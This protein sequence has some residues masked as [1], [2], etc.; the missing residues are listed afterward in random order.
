MVTFTFNEC[1]APVLRAGLA[2]LYPAVAGSIIA[3]TAYVWLLSRMRA[4]AVTSYA[5]VNP[6][7]ALLIG[8]WFGNET[9]GVRTVAGAALVLLS[10]VVV[11]RDQRA[12]RAL[13]Y[14]A[15]RNVRLMRQ[16]P[17]R[18]LM[19]SF[20]GATPWKAS[21]AGPPQTTTSPLSKR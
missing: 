9:P 2:I 1:R 19:P 4:T 13:S 14:K 12:P 18:S 21:R 20:S 7:V 11:T 5:Y 3:F 16:A 15:L 6:V 8:Q 10:V 17:V